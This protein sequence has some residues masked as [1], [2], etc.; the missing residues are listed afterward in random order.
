[1]SGFA[2]AL[3]E[4]IA[5]LLPQCA[6]VPACEAKLNDAKNLAVLAG[7]PSVNWLDRER[8]AASA[9]GI[10]DAIQSIQ[11]QLCRKGQHEKNG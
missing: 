11:P 4:I 9:G 3:L 8:A 5:T 10:V 2:A 1:M 7:D 6:G